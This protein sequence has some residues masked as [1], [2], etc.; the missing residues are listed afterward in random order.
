[1]HGRGG[2][3]RPISELELRPV[4][5][6]AQ[7]REL[8]PQHKQLDVF[9]VQAAPATNERVQ[10]SPNGEVEEG[11]GHAADPPNPLAP[12]Q[13]YRYWRPSGAPAG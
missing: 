12:P 8:V 3:R 5:L 6:P 10:Q 11:E 2:Q 9:H 1:M 7:D 13:R 4:N